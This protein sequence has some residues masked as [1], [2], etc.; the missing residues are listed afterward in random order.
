MNW[1]PH[2]GQ[3][4][5]W[6]GLRRGFLLSFLTGWGPARTCDGKLTHRAVC[7]VIF[8]YVG[9][10]ILFFFIKEHC[11]NCS[12]IRL[13]LFT[14]LFLFSFQSSTCG[15]RRHMWKKGHRCLRLAGRR[16]LLSPLVSAVLTSISPAPPRCPY[17]ATADTSPSKCATS[18]TVWPSLTQKTGTDSHAFN[19]LTTGSLQILQR[20]F[21][22]GQSPVHK[23]LKHLKNVLINITASSIQILI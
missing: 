10:L 12:Q 4:W 2:S 18:P 16:R 19:I 20:Y 14:D 15:K 21:M 6:S 13:R 11:G 1:F 8:E 5:E 23:C 7:F 17:K 22:R 9:L 3:L